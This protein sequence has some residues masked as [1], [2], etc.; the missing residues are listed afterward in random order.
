[1]L[2]GKEKVTPVVGA[3]SADD[4]AETRPAAGTT[5]PV[6]AAAVASIADDRI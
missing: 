1:M 6:P 4:E 5:Y 3:I 2:R